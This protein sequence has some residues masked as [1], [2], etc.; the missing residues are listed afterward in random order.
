M[1]VSRG[2]SFT[3]E[4]F[5]VALK[6]LVFEEGYVHADKHA[7]F[8]MAAEVIQNMILNS[9]RSL[10]WGF[11]FRTGVGTATS[12]L[13]LE[14]PPFERAVDRPEPYNWVMGLSR[15]IRRDRPGNWESA[16]AREIRKKTL[17]C[18]IGFGVMAAIYLG[19]QENDVLKL[20]DEGNFR[21]A[22]EDK[23]WKAPSKNRR[24]DYQKINELRETLMAED[25]LGFHPH[26]K[27]E[28]YQG[29]LRILTRENWIPQE[30]EY[31]EFYDF[32]ET[33][34][35]V[36]AIAV[37]LGAA[38]VAYKIVVQK[39]FPTNMLL[40]HIQKSYGDIGTTIVKTVYLPSVTP[41]LRWHERI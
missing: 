19:M 7:T 20:F 6:R 17:E 22:L 1:L 32:S 11:T 29:A 35:I 41:L 13:V 26:Y 33:T 9:P 3:L 40:H 15:Q 37:F 2:G 24:G 12:N 14:T 5:S 25:N 21:K 27:L 16:A 36:K 38:E 34:D 39:G 4:C 23:G 18:G 31:D 28:A 10:G 30:R 8:P